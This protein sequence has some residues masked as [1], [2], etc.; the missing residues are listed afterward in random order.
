MEGALSDLVDEQHVFRMTITG[1]HPTVSIVWHALGSEHAQALP[2]QM[3]NLLLSPLEVEAA[4]ETTRRA[5]EGVSREELLAGVRRFC[6]CSVCD[7]KLDEAVSFL[8][9]GLEAAI[10]RRSGF[11][12][13][14]CP[15]M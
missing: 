1:R 15:Q 9:N 5:Y 2:G 6:R 12:G 3:G 4:L 10:A 13:L 8:P 11:L 7:D 14:A